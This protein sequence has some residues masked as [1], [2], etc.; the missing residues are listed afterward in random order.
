M[1]SPQP[2]GR[3]TRAEN[4]AVSAA[5]V[6]RPFSVA[7]CQPVFEAAERSRTNAILVGGQAVNF[8]ATRFR[9]QV[10]RLAEFLP[11]TS[12][13]ADYLA[14]EEEANRLAEALHSQFRRAPRKGGMLGLALGDIPVGEHF[15]VEI[16]GRVNGVKR[17]VLEA[18][19]IQLASGNATVRVIHPVWLYIG[20]A[21]NLV[22]LNQSDRQDGKHLAMTELVLGAFL[23]QLAASTELETDK[24][25]LTLCELLIKFS[26]STVAQKLIRERMIDPVG[27]LPDFSAH[28]SQRLQNFYRERLPRWRKSFEPPATGNAPA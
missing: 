24:A 5:P 14:S 26:E 15:R 3:D 16:L 13:D 7:D 20:K 9:A 21:H 25:V 19:A 8:W 18:T 1:G 6:E 22:E 17:D 12:Q 27:A 23:G 4:G 2:G 28:P 10:P 11:F